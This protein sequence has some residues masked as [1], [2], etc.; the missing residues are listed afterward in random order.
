MVLWVSFPEKENNVKKTWA[1]DEQ[2]I[3]GREILNG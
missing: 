1:K 2:R 3:Q